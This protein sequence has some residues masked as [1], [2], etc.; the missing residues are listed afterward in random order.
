MVKYLC[1]KYERRVEPTNVCLLND[2]FPPL[3]DG[4]GNAVVNY[5]LNIQKNHGRSTVIVPK[6]PDVHDDYPFTVIRYPS[7]DTTKLVGYRA[8]YPFSSVIYSHTDKEVPDVIHSHCPAV[9][10]LVARTLRET[11]D[12]PLIFTYHT[13][14][15]IDISKAIKG[16]VFQK[17]ATDIFVD[18]ISAADEVWTVSR[19]AGE[20]LRALG[21]QGD[22]IIMKNGVD[23]PKGRVSDSEVSRL[24]AH[25]GISQELPVFLFVGRMMWYK[26]CRLTVDGL[27]E[28]KRR[29]SR[30]KM[31]FV[32]DGVD[33]DEIIAYT[34]KEGLASDCIFT[35]AVRDRQL[36]RT[37]FCLADLFMFPSTFDTNGIVAREAAA[38]SLASVMIKG[39]CAAE[40][41]THGVN[42]ILIDED[43][44]SMAQAITDACRDRQRLRKLGENAARDLYLSWED[45]VAIAAARYEK[46]IE[47]YKRNS[48]R[49]RTAISDMF[50]SEIAKNYKKIQ[51]FKE[52]NR[53]LANRTSEILRSLGEDGENTDKYL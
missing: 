45:A 30:F 33:L 49:K 6:Y 10:T 17:A 1:Y 41:V 20:N 34:E 7:I 48:E 21:Y 2:S 43:Q 36:L 32:G 14:F 37:F 22:Y 51:N 15:D 5:A 35:G 4:V 52:G 28:A 40:D 44:R 16:E 11:A 13:K 9:S 38:C 8:G 39:S 31:I 46:V 42:G 27:A 26:G 25:L 50:F 19:G 18:N 23:F 12:A 47:A 29:G 53:K 3:I 24:R